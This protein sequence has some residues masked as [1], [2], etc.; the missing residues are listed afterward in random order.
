MITTNGYPFFCVY[1]LAILIAAEVTSEP[2]LPKRT[3]SAQG[4]I[5]TNFSDNKIS[6]SVGNDKV[7]PF[8]SC[9]FTALIT[10]HHCIRDIFGKSPLTRSMYLFPSTSHT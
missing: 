4:I 5:F 9:F 6:S 10:S 1:D 7:I 2:F 8:V 3:F